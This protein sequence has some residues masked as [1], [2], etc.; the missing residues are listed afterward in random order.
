MLNNAWPGLIWH[1]Y[2][3]Y[4][5][6]AGGY[7]GTQKACEPLHVQYSYDDRSVVVANSLLHPYQKL[8]VRAAVYDINLKKAFSKEETV[9]IAPNSSTRVFVVPKLDNLSTTYFLRLTLKDS[10]GKLKS[11][12]FYWLST[13]ADVLDWQ[14]STWWYT[15]TSSYADFK[16]LRSLP[17]VR[18]DVHATTRMD[19]ARDVT[20]VRV[21]NPSS[22]L[23][24]FIHLR[25]NRGEHGHEILP[26][27]WQDNYFE[28]MPGEEREI[29]ASYSKE[30]LQ[31]TQPYV[32]INGW[33]I[34]AGSVA[35][36][37]E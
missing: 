19:D 10:E 31:G 12:N 14:K 24:F 26:V 30:A 4:L 11:M 1:L 15:P 35:A 34:A 23:A 16:E 18:L 2:D 7:F 28:L 37:M 17:Q 8:E 33:N 22:H 36:G 5:R 9:N 29:T 25:V 20:H 21:R 27:L 3:Y 32:A 6:P 13:K